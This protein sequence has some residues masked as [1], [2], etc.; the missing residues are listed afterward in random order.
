MLLVGSGHHG[1][2]HGAIMTARVFDQSTMGKPWEGLSALFSWFLVEFQDEIWYKLLSHCVRSI[3]A[4]IAGV[5][6]WEVCRA[7]AGPRCSA[8]DLIHMLSN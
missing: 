8:A 7:M 4:E 6:P 2:L 3:A 5:G 1:G